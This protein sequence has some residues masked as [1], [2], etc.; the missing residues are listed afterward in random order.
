MKQLFL[1]LALNYIPRLILE[2]TYMDIIL[3]NYMSQGTNKLTKFNRISLKNF[4]FNFFIHERERE[5]QKHRQK[6]K[7]TPHKEPDAGL[8]PGPG[9]H[10]ELKANTQ[11]LSHPVVPN[12]VS[13]YHH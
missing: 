3:L 2:L 13:L 12:C 4:F 9:S 8:D 7:Q 6:E 11:P 5:R 1:C 10:P